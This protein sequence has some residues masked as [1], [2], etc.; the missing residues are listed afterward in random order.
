[1]AEEHFDFETLHVER[2][3][4]AEWLTLNR[5]E[6]L[7]ALNSAMV[8]ELNAYFSGLKKR[9]ETRVVVLK[10]NG[11]AFC[12]GLDLAEGVQGGVRDAYAVQTAIGDI[13]KGIA[14]CP[15]PVIALLHG[16]ACGG[17]FTLA[18]AADIRLAA[19]NTRM[20]AAFIKIG[21]TGCDMGSSYFLPRL[22][23]ASVASEL[24][25][26]GRFIDADRALRVNLVSDVVEKDQ[27]EA[28]A[29][30][31]IDDMLQ[32][33]PMGLRLTKQALRLALDAPSLDA[34][35]AL[36]DRHQVMLTQTADQIEAVAAFLEKRAPSYRDR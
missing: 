14:N 6:Q 1:M 10:A 2:R 9:L 31:L 29:Q 11:R 13:M 21:L 26:T 25:L 27:L 28:S 19:P 30:A 33:A 12:A 35:M 3:G 20:N 22:V 32:T 8:E 23:G 34:A 18:L 5:P 4:A 24:L 15:Q 16:A 17:G 7:N 36:E